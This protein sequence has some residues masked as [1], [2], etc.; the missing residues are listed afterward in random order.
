M[1]CK[2]LYKLDLVFHSIFFIILLIVLFRV[3]EHITKNTIQLIIT[4]YKCKP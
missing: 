1:L 4:N 3:F 2:L